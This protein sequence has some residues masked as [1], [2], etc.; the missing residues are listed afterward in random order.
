MTTILGIN[1]FSHDTAACVLRDGAPVAFVEE[2]RFNRECH[3]KAFPEQAVSY[4]LDA[5]GVAMRDVDVV[6]FAH[7]P[8]V[9]LRRGW[10]DA[11]RRVAPKRAAG[12]GYVDARLVGREL[13]FRRR[14]GYRGRIVRVGHHQA[15]AGAAFYASPFERAAVLTIDRGGDFVSTGMGIGEGKA[16][17]TVGLV[18]NPHSLGELYSAF[19][20]FLG[21]TPNADEGKVMGLAP[22]G[23]PR[24]VEEL[25]P[26]ISLEA[27]GRFRIDLSWFGFHRE[28]AWFS[29][30]FV[31]R[32]GP[33]RLAES[34]ITDR[35]QDLAYAVQTLVEEAALHLAR[36]LRARTNTTRLCLGGGVALNSV[37]NGRLLAET[38]FEEIFVQPAAADAGNALGAALWVWHRMLGKPRAWTMEHAALGPEYSDAACEA[39]LDASGIGYRR[40]ADVAVEAARLLAEGRIVGWFQGRAEAGPRALGQRSILADPR[41]PTMKDSINARVKHRESFRP[42]APAVLDEH[43]PEYFDRYTTNPFMLFVVPVRPDRRAT[44]PAVAHV[45]G[46]ARVQ[47]VRRDTDARLARLI[48]AF[49][50]STG[51]PVVLNTSFNVRGEPIVLRPEEAVED[52]L[53]TG[54]DA[55]ALGPYLAC[56][57]QHG[58]TAD[59]FAAANQASQARGATSPT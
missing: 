33:A 1:C 2:E 58:S 22:Y 36:W 7:R 29:R 46:T 10:A 4:C 35:D 31:E 16:L 51:I 5:A 21:F 37:C 28:G 17:R 8:L 18:R 47:S 55:L 40:V 44:I 48:E 38:E 59:P 3:T 30:R 54:L 26:M 19:T 11:V 20:W 23:T 57:E 49:A 39:A 15:H 6:A 27:E 24:F 56:K 25:R 42:F 41:S 45:D 53:R 43:G 12:Q 32:F 13:M 50:A 52:F 34:E 9:D 14:F